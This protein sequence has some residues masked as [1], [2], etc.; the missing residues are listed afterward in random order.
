[1]NISLTSK[2][3]K[4]IKSCASIVRSVTVSQRCLKMIKHYPLENIAK[5]LFIENPRDKFLAT[6]LFNCL[7]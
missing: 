4:I 6:N 3:I 2:D 5:Q 1:M 7:F